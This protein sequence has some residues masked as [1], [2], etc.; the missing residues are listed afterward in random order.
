MKKL[1]ALLLAL[2][3][4]ASFAACGGGKDTPVSSQEVS[5]AESSEEPVDET[6]AATTALENALKATAELDYEKIAKYYEEPFVTKEAMEYLGESGKIVELFIKKA[7]ARVSDCKQTDEETATATIA[8]SV[9]DFGKL[10]NELSPKLMEKVEKM[11]AENM[12]QEQMV[13]LQLYSFGLIE[14]AFKGDVATVSKTI[15]MELKKIDGEWKVS[16]YDEFYDAVLGELE[17]AFSYM[18]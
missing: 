18:Q 15:K 13:E 2:T 5:S 16:D 4:L 6:E 8:L 3:M 10:V 17:T 11:D 1:L 7:Q 12:T 14:E 9:V